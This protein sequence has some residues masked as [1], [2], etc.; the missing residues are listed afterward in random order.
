[1]INNTFNY[2][3]ATAKDLA[4]AL[5]RHNEVSF[6]TFYEMD[7]NGVIDTNEDWFGAAIVN[8]FYGYC[9]LVT[10]YGGGMWF[11]YNAT[12]ENEMLPLNREKVESIFDHLLQHDLKVSDGT[13]CVEAVWLQS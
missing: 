2:S 4:D 9:I 5:L 10:S 12:P 6:A 1:M 3:K 8:Q 11:A 13:V 7:S